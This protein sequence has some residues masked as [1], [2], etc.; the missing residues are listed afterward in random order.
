MTNYFFPIA[1]LLHPC[2]YRSGL[3]RQLGQR[4]RL[5][6]PGAITSPRPA[7]QG[8]PQQRQAGRLLAPLPRQ[9]GRPPLKRHQRV[10]SGA[11]LIQAAAHAVAA[12]TTSSVRRT[13]VSEKSQPNK[14][15]L[16]PSALPKEAEDKKRG[17]QTSAKDGV[18]KAK[19]HVRQRMKNLEEQ[20]AAPKRT[21][22][23]TTTTAHRSTTRPPPSV[24]VK[25]SS[26]PVTVL[27]MRL[28]L[29]RRPGK[30]HKR[31]RHVSITMKLR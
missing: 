16:K 3:V 23:P 24:M 7:P 20:R 10:S 5:H 13:T 25:R 30:R 19:E 15:K 18:L 6:R 26:S 21:V 11:A 22:V 12:T 28:L 2:P 29:G 9:E 17:A 8:R 27:T 1:R 14:S 31:R 4:R